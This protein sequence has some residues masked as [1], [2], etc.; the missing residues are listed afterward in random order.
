MQVCAP[1]HIL[2]YPLSNPKE[3]AK[4]VTCTGPAPQQLERVQDD[5]QDTGTQPGSSNWR[6]MGK[7]YQILFGSDRE[8]A[9]LRAPCRHVM[10]QS[11][12]V[13]TEPC[14]L[15]RRRVT[16]CRSPHCHALGFDCS[17]S[18]MTSLLVSSLHAIELKGVLN[19]RT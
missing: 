9:A 14:R 1:L 5:V 19:V 4:H 12:Y 3:A 7:H 15:T 6:Y 2:L 10:R 13:I 8:A 17:H 16:A 11:R 18:E